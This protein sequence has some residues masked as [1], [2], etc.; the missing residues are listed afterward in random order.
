M[1]GITVKNLTMVRTSPFFLQHLMKMSARRVAEW[2]PK[3]ALQMISP[4][5]YLFQLQHSIARTSIIYIG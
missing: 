1:W 2:I 4:I 5:M 3:I